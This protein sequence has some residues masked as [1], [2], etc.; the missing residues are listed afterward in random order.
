MASTNHSDVT[1]S[2]R[3]NDKTCSSTTTATTAIA[4]LVPCCC[5]CDEC[6]ETAAQQY[7][8]RK[9]CPTLALLK[10]HPDV[11]PCRAGQ[12]EKP[13]SPP[14]WLHIRV[15]RSADPF[16]NCT[17]QKSFFLLFR[18]WAGIRDERCLPLKP[19]PNTM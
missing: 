12:T 5:C 16:I 13:N 7:M 1:G 14:L 2:S 3:T 19:L 18:F 15:G 8:R 10:S 6:V 9:C 4:T 11:G 17:H